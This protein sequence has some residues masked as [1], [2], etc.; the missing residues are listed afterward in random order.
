MYT[1]EVTLRG[2]PL[3]L[4]VQRKETDDAEALYQKILTAVQ[5]SSPQL[6]ELTCDRD[7]D[8]KIGVLSSEISAVQISDKSSG[9]GGANVP[10]FFAAINS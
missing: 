7:T 2:T 8:K 6:L 4:A 9:G 3:A 1:I 10:G 5:S